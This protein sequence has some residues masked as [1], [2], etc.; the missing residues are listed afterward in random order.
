MATGRLLVIVLFCLIAA[1]EAAA[2]SCPFATIDDCPAGFNRILGT[3]SSET[4]NGTAGPDC[5]LGLGGNDTINGGGGNDIIC[6]G[7]GGDTISGGDGDD[8]MYGDDG[9]DTI[10]G[11]AGADQLFGGLGTD[12]L[13]GGE[14]P[15]QL[16]GGDGTDRLSGGSGNDFLD[17]GEGGNNVDGGSGTDVCINGTPS[18]CE[19]LT[20]VALSGLRAELVKGRLR[21]RWVTE[22]EAGALGY[23]VRRR[24]PDGLFRA[25]PQGVVPALHGSPLGGEYRLNDPQ[26]AQQGERLVYEIVERG[27]GVAE[28]HGP[29]E[30]TVTSRRDDDGAE[31]AFEQRGREQRRLARA[32]KDAGEAGSVLARRDRDVRASGQ[33]K[34]DQG[35]EED[36]D[37]DEAS[38]EG[39][40]R[41]TDP[42]ALKIGVGRTGMVRLS[43]AELATRFGVSEGTVG[44]WLTERQLR[45]TTGG[46]VVSWWAPRDASGLVFY[47]LASTS[48][49]AGERVYFLR[50]G[51]GRVMGSEKGRG[52]REPAA[53]TFA[54][55]FPAS[56]AATVRAE[57]ERFPGLVAE[58]DPEGDIWFWSVLMSGFSG[59][60]VFRAP[61]AVDAL[62]PAGEAELRLR[63]FGASIGT[64]TLSVRIN[65]TV[66]GE[67]T[68]PGTGAALAAVRFDAALLAEGTNEIEVRIAR[69]ALW[70]T[71]I[72][73][74]D[75]L[76]LTY[77]RAFQGNGGQLE[78]SAAGSV[79]VDVTDPEAQVFDIGDPAAP[80]RLRAPR[81]VLTEAGFRLG[82]ATPREGGRYLVVENGAWLA[83]SWARRDRP[84]SWRDDDVSAEYVVIAPAAHLTA[85]R[86]LADARAEAGL[87]TAVVDVE[88]IYDEL[89]DGAASPHAIRAFLEHAVTRWTVPPRYV[90]LAGAGSYDFK[91]VYGWHESLVPPFLVPTGHGLYASD[92]L[93]AD[94]VGADGVADLAIGRLPARSAAE[95]ELMVDKILR[96]ERAGSPSAGGLA[97]VADARDGLVDFAATGDALRARL[98]T[99]TSRRVY[100]DELGAAAARAATARAFGE[101]SIVTYLG[102]GSTASLGKRSSLLAVGD[103]AAL[104]ATDTPPLML[105]MTCT[106]GRF[107]LPGYEGLAEKLLARPD[108]G[109]IAVVSA[110]ALS[111]H[112]AATA[113][114]DALLT[115][116]DEDAGQS[117]LGDA[118]LAAQSRLAATGADTAILRTYNLLGDPASS[119]SVP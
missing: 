49:W 104:P 75:D 14:G 103:V 38:D 67:A 39:R 87:T 28:T 83:P 26:G 100:L 37:D 21:L 40:A 99:S 116:I 118:L 62:V 71:S 84:S 6:G 88:D 105:A 82:F 115:V 59:Y 8:V 4:L 70:G 43:T 65:G 60:D 110:S 119:L 112:G 20:P 97:L 77:P 15:D 27:A 23:E 91:D 54:A 42:I 9:T 73:Y 50:R 95:L 78:L 64:H 7:T 102:H 58:P 106:M 92:T 52:G 3:D 31:G 57:E 13:S 55:T 34:R 66:V 44:H 90:V 113:F 47:G 74:V 61:L 45:L 94:V 68:P 24:G 86:R 81:R 117:R 33:D 32:S 12:R 48:A 98:P 5:I 56:F 41:S 108:G 36:E 89:G 53:A 25:L 17:G 2:Q 11:D 30:V 109:A 96:A 76:E 80:T 101:A 85:A 35:D 72:V 111:E 19:S 22:N 51:P 46:H 1:T 107:E 93:L 69:R 10:N 63:V 18:G 79:S 114:V 16:F 29:F